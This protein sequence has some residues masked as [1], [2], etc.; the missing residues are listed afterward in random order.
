MADVASHKNVHMK[1]SSLLQAAETPST[2]T[3]LAYYKPCLD[4]LVSQFGEDRIFYGSNWPVTNKF[5]KYS[6]TKKIVLEFCKAH[7]RQ[8]A[9]KLFYKNALKFY[10][11]PAINDQ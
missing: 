2:P 5:G 4:F 8:F 3:D 7:D 6:D 11:R 9:E 1:I 10:N